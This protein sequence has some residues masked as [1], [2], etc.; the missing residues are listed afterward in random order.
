MQYIFIVYRVCF[1]KYKYIFFIEYQKKKIKIDP[2][3]TDFV[4][5]LLR[6]IYNIYNAV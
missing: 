3:L 4:L 1:E 2:I 6:G 5:M